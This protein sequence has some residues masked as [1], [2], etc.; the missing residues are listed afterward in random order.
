MSWLK[1]EKS[2][3]VSITVHVQPKSS[4]NRIA[5]LHGEAVKICVTAP[6]VDGKANKAVIAFL[7][8]FFNIPKSSVT[9]IKGA[10]SRSKRFL[11]AGPTLAEVKQLVE[12][13]HQK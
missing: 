3:S 5:G 11:L 10:Q 8:N 12:D 9:L 13:A 6:P 1:A 7:S 4:R 2:G